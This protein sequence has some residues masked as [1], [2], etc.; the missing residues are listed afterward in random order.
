MNVALG[1]VDV[2]REFGTDVVFGIPGGAISPMYA[3]LLDRPEIRIVTNKHES[4]AAFMALGYAIA[5][6]RPGV[7]LTTAGPGITNA[8]TGV[9]SA[10]YEAVPVVH[11]AGEVARSACSSLASASAS[12]PRAS[13]TGACRRA[14][15]SARACSIL[16][17]WVRIHPVT[18]RSHTVS[19]EVAS[20]RAAT[21]ALTAGMSVRA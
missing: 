2:L 19:T 15:T 17:R 12:S 11:I 21:A 13:S 14:S 10:Y 7:V 3:A 16:M 5:T 18:E 1:I 4:N 6:G 8:M 20:A 9:A